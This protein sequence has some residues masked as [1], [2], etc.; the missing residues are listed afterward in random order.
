MVVSREQVFREALDL[1]PNDWA[2]FGKLLIESLDCVSEGGGAG[3]DGEISCRA[4][5]FD[6][7]VVRTSLGM[8]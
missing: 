4:V 7:S 3:V 6:S 8:P 1:E 5:A 2:E